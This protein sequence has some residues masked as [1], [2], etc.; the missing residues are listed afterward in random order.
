MLLHKNAHVLCH[1]PFLK[2]ETVR[3]PP[4]WAQVWTRKSGSSSKRDMKEGSTIMLPCRPFDGVDKSAAPPRAH[5]DQD[6]A[7]RLRY[8]RLVQ[9]TLVCTLCAAIRRP[10]R[11]LVGQCYPFDY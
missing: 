11:G 9:T 4:L 5:C 1:R 6:K 7:S 2:L 3:S 10:L 8:S